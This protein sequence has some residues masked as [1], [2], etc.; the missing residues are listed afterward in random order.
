MRFF[1][2]FLASLLSLPSHANQERPLNLQIIARDSILIDQEVLIRF[3]AWHEAGQ[4]PQDFNHE[5]ELTLRQRAIK[6]RLFEIT[7][8]LAREALAK[9]AKPHTVAQF[10]KDR[11]FDYLRSRLE[12]LAVLVADD[13]SKPEDIYVELLINQSLL[14]YIGSSHYRPVNVEERRPIL[15]LYERVTALIRHR[16]KIYC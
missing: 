10:V 8:E 6:D 3:E 1:I 14:M 4:D 16:L 12:Y 11:G 15:K 2:C 5:L 9:E 13:K 7:D